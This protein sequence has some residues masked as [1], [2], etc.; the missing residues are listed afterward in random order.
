M[1]S[2]SIWVS[3]SIMIF[4]DGNVFYHSSLKC[5]MIFYKQCSILHQISDDRIKNWKTS[6]PGGAEDICCVRFSY[7]TSNYD[8][9]IPNFYWR[10]LILLPL[11]SLL[12]HPV[13]FKNR[14][15]HFILYWTCIFYFK[16][17]SI[18]IPKGMDNCAEIVYICIFKT[19]LKWLNGYSAS[20]HNC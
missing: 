10:I 12:K 9:Q 15:S 1:S 7:I 18:I 13:V 2:V 17:K 19:K 20:S 11:R 4:Y 14:N 16:R 6:K 3:C 5:N 8:Y